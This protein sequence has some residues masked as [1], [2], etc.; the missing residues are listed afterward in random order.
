MHDCHFQLCCNCIPECV[1]IGAS[2]VLMHFSCATLVTGCLITHHD[3]FDV[4]IQM[5]RVCHLHESPYVDC[6][7]HLPSCTK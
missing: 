2:A 4:H 5:C 1:V 7:H 6:L 3:R